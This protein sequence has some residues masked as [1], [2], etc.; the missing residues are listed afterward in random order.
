MRDAVVAAYKQPKATEAD[1]AARKAAIQHAL[2]RATDVPLGVMR[3]S[4]MGLGH[5]KA[6]AAHG[7]QAASSDVGVAVALLKAGLQGARLNVEINLDG[8]SDAAY[9]EAVG[10]EAERL[11][12]T[13]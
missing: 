3:L 12:S 8:L 7:H 4:A 5:A 2:R 11:A 6:V 13:T 1:Q 10:A 9:T